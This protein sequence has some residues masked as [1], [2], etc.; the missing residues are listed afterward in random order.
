MVF[1]QMGTLQKKVIH[2]KIQSHLWPS[3]P[4]VLGKIHQF[5]PRI[6][7]ISVQVF[8][9]GEGKDDFSFKGIKVYLVSSYQGTQA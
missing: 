2:S 3:L 7:K 6:D 8:K 5:L 9:Q 1:I 4:I